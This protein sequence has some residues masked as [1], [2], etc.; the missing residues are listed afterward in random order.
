MTSRWTLAAMGPPARLSQERLGG[1]RR[2]PSNHCSIR[3]ESG[4]ADRGADAAELRRGL[5]TEEGDRDD[6]HHGD[7]G[8]EE[9]VLHE[10]STTLV[11]TALEVRTKELDCSHWGCLPY[12][13]TLPRLPEVQ[14]RQKPQRSIGIRRGEPN[15]AEGLS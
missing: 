2:P 7:E 5:A 8:H 9:G 6:A 14:T 10:R 13:D 11:D 1:R 15:R 12:L 3:S 4:A